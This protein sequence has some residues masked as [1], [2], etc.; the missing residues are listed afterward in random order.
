MSPLTRSFS[1]RLKNFTS[2]SNLS[3]LEMDVI[4]CKTDSGGSRLGRLSRS[5][6]IREDST[7]ALVQI[8]LKFSRSIY[9]RYSVS[10]LG[11]SMKV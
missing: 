11:F 6:I 5:D 7:E 8:V 1:L 9:F 2:I 4:M 10:A 3:T